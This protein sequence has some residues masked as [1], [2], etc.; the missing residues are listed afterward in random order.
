MKN[1]KMML[2]IAA[3]LLIT[4]LTVVPGY[5]AG[6]RGTAV[7][8]DAGSV[9]GGSD[10]GYKND[11]LKRYD[12]FFDRLVSEGIIS[13]DQKSAIKLAAEAAVKEA[14]ANGGRKID[15]STVLASLVREGKLTQ[16]QMAAIEAAL[17][18]ERHKS[19]LRRIETVLDGLMKDGTITQAQEKAILSAVADAADFAGGRPDLDALLLSLSQY[20]VISEDQRAAIERA[21]KPAHHV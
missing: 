3:V 15:M 12:R 5:S 11:A 10:G 8:P 20:G 13:A 21:L 1:R 9:A 18:S 16:A 6:I 2:F 14:H 17:R 7:P 19:V 4:S